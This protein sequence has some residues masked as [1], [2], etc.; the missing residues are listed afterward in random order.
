M[1]KSIL[2]YGNRKAARDLSEVLSR[3]PLA[4]ETAQTE[5]DLIREIRKKSPP[6]AIVRLAKTDRIEKS[7]SA[8]LRAAAS[9][10]KTELMVVAERREGELAL[11]AKRLGV[12]RTVFEPYNVRELIASVN[13][14]IVGK[15]RW[16]SLGGGTGL[17]HLLLGLKTIP[18]L[19]LTSIVSMSDDGG[20]SGRL[21]IS[22][23]VL[24]P[25]D[26]RRSL[27][28][29]SNAPELMNQ[30]IQHRFRKGEGL[31]DHSFGNLFL[32]ALSEIKGNM[33]EAIRA[34]GDILNIQGIVLPAATTLTDLEATFEDGT[35]IRGE[36]KIDLAEGRSP[37]LR[38]VDFK[39]RPEAVYNPD[40]YGAI[41]DSDFVTIGPGDLFTS[42]IANLTVRGVKE[43][44]SKTKA[45][46]IYFCNLMTKPGETAH[47]TAYDHVREIIKYMGGDYLDYVFFSDTPVSKA[48]L[49]KYARKDQEPVLAE[50]L[51]RIR[52]LTK[53]KLVVADL[54]HHKELIRHDGEKI[55]RAVN[56]LL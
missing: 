47:F 36:S 37:D 28:A 8:K 29:L 26:V 20:S 25:G 19:L 22:H 17:Y 40:A 9:K 14:L 15:K 10:A 43:A 55:K 13:A 2:L 27:V 31:R 52:K 16:A 4:V 5:K 33:C 41:L 38:I 30:V 23:G 6:V 50:G 1:I 39:H 42:V 32:T 3:L 24:P 45:K 46:K 34:L 7:I 56:F 21:R 12:A 35:V 44:L 53:A 18:N 48:A 54:G 51:K 49:S 11:K